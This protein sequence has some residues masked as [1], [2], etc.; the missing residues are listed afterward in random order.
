MSERS[1]RDG[2]V[3]LGVNDYYKKYGSDYRNPHEPIIRELLLILIQK[4]IIGKKILDLCCGSGEVTMMVKDY[5][6]T[7][8]DPY[9]AAAYKSRTGKELLELS[10]IDISKGKLSGKYDSII[11]S[12]ALHLCPQSLLPR[13][14]WRLGEISNTLIIITPHKRPDCDNIS[15]W[16]LV[17]EI[18]INRVRMRIYLK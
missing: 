17:E 12:F 7:G 15:G 11:C 1:V 14:L 3:E 16:F 4:N 5:E 9:T 13:L 18:M 6:V 8:L 2:Y 10:F